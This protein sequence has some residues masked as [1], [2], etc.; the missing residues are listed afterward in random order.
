MIAQTVQLGEVAEFTMGQAPPGSSVNTEER[1]TPFYRSGEFGVRRPS[2]AAWTTNPLRTSQPEDV[3]VCVVGANAGDINLGAHGAIGRSVAAISSSESLDYLY[4]YYYLRFRERW[5]RDQAAGSAQPVLSKDDLCRLEIP[6]PAIETQ[7]AIAS[8][9]G[10]LDDKI[11]SN[12]NSVDIANKLSRAIFKA[13]PRKAVPASSVLKPVLGGTPKR[14]VASYWGGT[15]KWA[16]AK[17]VAASTGGFILD[18]SEMITESGVSNSAAKV[19][20]AGT[21][22][23][24]AR[25]TVGALARLGEPMSFNQSCYGLIATNGDAA[26]LHCAVEDAI[27]RIRDAGHGTVFNTINMATFQQIILE[28]PAQGIVENDLNEISNFTKHLLIENQIL[29]KLR[30]YLLPEL[31]SGRLSIEGDLE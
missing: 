18:T 21:T 22:I 6:L 30:D 23:I 9:L 3:W 15:N 17:D 25:G 2:L 1:G 16:S 28:M 29:A 8:I 24:T 12:T 27:E 4:L 11:E 10:T 13:A 31:L 5:L 26:T 14:E 20:P 7:R 19:L